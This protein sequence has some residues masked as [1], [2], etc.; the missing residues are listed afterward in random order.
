MDEVKALSPTAL[1]P[2]GCRMRLFEYLQQVRGDSPD[3]DGGLGRRPGAAASGGSSGSGGRGLGRRPGAE[4]PA[5]AAA[6]SSTAAAAV[7]AHCFVNIEQNAS[8][9]RA[10]AP[11]VSL[12]PTLMRT[13][14]LV[15]I[16][17]A[18]LGNR[19]ATLVHPLEHYA[20][21]GFP[22]PC[23][24]QCQSNADR[25]PF[26]GLLHDGSAECLDP[27]EM[28]RLTGNGMH[29]AAL[30]AWLQFILACFEPCDSDSDSFP[31]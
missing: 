26:P 4:T 12:F 10:T 20:A 24:C 11:G 22:V 30:G 27:A 2:A 21:M 1:V 23:M 16:G 7:P 9:M 18:R 5:A 29:C 17:T 14:T 13:S 8:F 28:R 31:P 19:G 25:C 3:P 15:D 6:A